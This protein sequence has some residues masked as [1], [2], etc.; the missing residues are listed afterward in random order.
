MI[1]LPEIIAIVIA[2]G[3]LLVSSYKALTDKPRN[4]ADIYTKAA[5]A[6]IVPLNDEIDRLK[7]KLRKAALVQ[8][9]LLNAL[10]AYLAA[11]KDKLKDY[12]YCQPCLG[13]DEVFRV[14]IQTII[15]NGETDADTIQRR[16]RLINS[17]KEE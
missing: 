2:V 8:A 14:Q 5:Q 9:A 12:P 16:K 13:A 11:R 3:G 6:L 4:D 17:D 1:T 10:Y 7:E 15:T